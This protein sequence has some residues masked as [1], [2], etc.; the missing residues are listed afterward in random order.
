[1]KKQVKVKLRKGI[2][3]EGVG[4]LEDAIE[5]G[6]ADTIGRNAGERTDAERQAEASGSG[7]SHERGGEFS[8]R[9]LDSRKKTLDPDD[10]LQA[11]KKLKKAVL[12][13][14]RYVLACCVA[15]T[16]QPIF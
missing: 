11:K 16:M 4:G 1:M 13:H 14:Y 10:Y 12:E 7:T 9:Q 6:M 5:N 8:P 3:A 2:D 15:S